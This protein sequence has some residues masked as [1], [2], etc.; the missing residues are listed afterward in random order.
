MRT[1][2]ANVVQRALRKPDQRLAVR[3]IGEH[4]HVTLRREDGSSSSAVLRFEPGV[5]VAVERDQMAITVDGQPSTVGSLRRRAV[6]SD[7]WRRV[8]SK[9]C[10]WRG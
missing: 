10:F 1:D 3:Q 4:L 2:W 5:D 8:R 7:R 9:L 6:W